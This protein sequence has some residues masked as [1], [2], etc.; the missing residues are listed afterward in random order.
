VAKLILGRRGFWRFPKI[1]GLVCVP[2]LRPDGT[3]LNRAGFD[4]DTGLF[5][6]DPPP[7]PPLPDRPTKDD[8]ATGLALLNEL[9]DEF[10]FVDGPSRSVALSGLITPVVRGMFDVVPMHGYSSPQAGTGK[11]YL[12]DLASVLI[13]GQKCATSTV[14]RSEEENEKRLG[15]TLLAGYPAISLDNVDIPLNSA[16]LC[17][18]IERSWLEL[19]V[20]GTSNKPRVAPSL[21]LFCTGNNLSLVGDLVRRTVLALLDAKCERPWTRRFQRNPLD[22]LLAAR[23]HYIAA[24]LNIVRAYLAAGKPSQK[25]EPFAS[26]ETWSNTRARGVGVVG[27]G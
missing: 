5:L 4:A 25:L 20:L 3:L 24:A 27:S 11:S 19:R 12:A 10:P 8:A 22:M 1:R 15:G 18:V 9:L 23:G 16:F 13:S 14:S 2:T 7:L 26:F 17:Q 21:T 6:L